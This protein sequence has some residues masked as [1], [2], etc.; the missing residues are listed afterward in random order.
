MLFL[1][2]LCTNIIHSIHTTLTE[3]LAHHMYT[4][5]VIVQQDKDRVC[6]ILGGTDKKLMPAVCAAYLDVFGSTL[7]EQLKKETLV[8]GDF[9]A[10][11]LAWCDC[12]DPTNGLEYTVQPTEPKALAKHLLAERMNLRAH[13]AENDAVLIYKACKV[14]L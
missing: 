5:A 6:R 9:L 1:C 8:T 3:L 2:T 12:K 10:A 4:P 13:I 7:Q 11:T 14:R